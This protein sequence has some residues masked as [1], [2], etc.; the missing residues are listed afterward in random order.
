MNCFLVEKEVVKLWKLMWL[1]SSY[2]YTTT[3]NY[4]FN[5]FLNFIWDFFN[6]QIL[7]KENQQ[8]RLIFFIPIIE[9]LT[10]GAAVMLFEDLS[11]INQ[12]QEDCCNHSSRFPCVLWGNNFKGEKKI[13]KTWHNKRSYNKNPEEKKKRNPHTKAKLLGAE[14]IKFIR[15]GPQSQNHQ[16]LKVHTDSSLH[17]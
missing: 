6:E 3:Y 9:F 14:K 7:G 16:L 10:C 4:K 1:Q 15:E 13:T 17:P 12:T 8:T 5:A 11:L 2:R